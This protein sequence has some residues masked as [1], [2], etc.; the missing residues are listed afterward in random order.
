[1]E[2]ADIDVARIESS[3]PSHFQ[4]E[5]FSTTEILCIEITPSIG[6]A[7][8]FGTCK[9][10]DARRMALRTGRTDSSRRDRAGHPHRRRRYP[11]T[12]KP[13]RSRAWKHANAAASR[14]PRR[15]V[16]QNLML[17]VSMRPMSCAAR[18]EARSLQVP[19]K[20]SLDRLK[21][22]VP[23][24]LSVLVPVRLWML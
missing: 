9:P 19:F 6:A 7:S 11:Y 12:K 10:I 14:R 13:G 3:E 16:D 20:A 22:N 4:Q 24:T 17:Q 2:D 5:N 8:S 1:M 18:S 23:L 21:V 15:A